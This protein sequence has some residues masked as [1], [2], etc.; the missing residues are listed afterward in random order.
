MPGLPV[1]AWATALMAARML[2]TAGEVNTA[3]AMTPVSIPF[4]MKPETERW[5]EDV[6]GGPVPAIPGAPHAPGL[7]GLVSPTVHV[8]QKSTCAALPRSIIS[9]ERPS[10][11]SQM[12]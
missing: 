9:L 3:P 5:G 2:P 12:K 4:P 1:P 8:V 6:V 10:P 11:T 7:H